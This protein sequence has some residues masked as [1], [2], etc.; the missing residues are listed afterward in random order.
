[1][2]RDVE[3]DFV[4]YVIFINQTIDLINVSRVIIL[5]MVLKQN[6]LDIFVVV[7]GFV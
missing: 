3:D 4:M 7:T 5:R 6:Q 1:M 2:V